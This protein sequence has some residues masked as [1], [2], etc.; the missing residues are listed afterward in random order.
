MPSCPLSL[1]ERVRVRGLSYCVVAFNAG[2]LFCR[3]LL[4]LAG[5]GDIVA[6]VGLKETLTGD[7]ICDTR[8]PVCLPSISF[9]RTVI[10]MAIEPR[11][12][13]ER[14]K[15]ADAIAALRREDPTFGCRLDKETGQTMVFQDRRFYDQKEGRLAVEP[16]DWET[17]TAKANA[18][19]N[20]QQSENQG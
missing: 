6:V 15:L 4:D 19:I 14:A 20:S 5:A 9:P 12:A 3:K 1:R 7:T 17:P 11:T 13:A 8:H 18:E 16:Y 10:N 2:R